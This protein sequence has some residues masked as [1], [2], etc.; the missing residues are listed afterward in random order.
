MKTCTTREVDTGGKLSHAFERVCDGTKVGGIY[1]VK[2][3]V[4]GL[5]RY[6]VRSIY[7]NSNARREGHATKLYEAA[8]QYACSRGSGLVSAERNPGAHSND[9]W[10]KMFSKGKARKFGVNKNGAIYEASCWTAHDL[11]GARKT[12]PKASGRCVGVRRK[13]TKRCSEHSMKENIRHCMC[14][15]TRKRDQCVAIAY[16]QLEKSCGVH[17]RKKTTP[18][19]IVAAAKAKRRRK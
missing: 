6:V 13:M 16:A 10:Q 19:K 4:K 5:R 17:P 15:T 14:L 7:V 18:K 12:M 9:F 3:T 2:R 11:S 8:A 1:I